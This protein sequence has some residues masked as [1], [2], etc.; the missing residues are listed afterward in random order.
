VIQ[1]SQSLTVVKLKR[2]KKMIKYTVKVF[3]EGSKI[4]YLN[5]Q[6]HREDG[7]AMEWYDGDKAWYLNGQ[8]HR[9]DGPAL[10]YSSGIKCWYLNG[11]EYT[12]EE[13]NLKMN[14]VTVKELS[15]SEISQLL[16]YEIKVVK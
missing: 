16:G 14:R 12:E 3:S 7:P 11:T 13:Y 9:E 5:G 15:V 4:W 2:R 1:Q 10:E 6:L 8:Y